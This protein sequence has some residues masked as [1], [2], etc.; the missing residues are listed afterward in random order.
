MRQILAIAPVIQGQEASHEFDILPFQQ[1]APEQSNQGSLIDFGDDEHSQA[2]AS[3][4]Q[5]PS[6]K[7]M[8]LLGVDDQESHKENAASSLGDPPELMAP[9]KPTVS[10]QHNIRKMDSNSSDVDDFVDAQG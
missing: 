7:D 2:A 1:S 8:D 9:L 6:N 3:R 10:E 4:K 5:E